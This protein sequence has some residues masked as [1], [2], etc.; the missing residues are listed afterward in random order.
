MPRK[1]NAQEKY[2]ED[3]ESE[4]TVLG[5]VLF[6][7]AEFA[8]IADL[9]QE[10]FHT[11]SNQTIFLV[12]R[13][14]ERRGDPVDNVSLANEL[15]DRKE[16]DKIGGL[17]YLLGLAD[18]VPP[19][20]NLPRYKQR[21]QKK[22]VTRQVMF[23]A[24]ATLDHCLL[25]DEPLDKILASTQDS[26]ADIET[27]Y[28][29]T[30]GNGKHTIE[31]LPSVWEY[32]IEMHWLLDG[33]IAQGSVTMLTG[34][35]GDGKSFLSL[36]LAGQVARGEPFLSRN[37]IK[38]RVLYLDRENPLFVVKERLALMNIRETKDLTYWGTWNDELPDGPGSAAIIN[39]VEKHKPLVIFDN[40]AAFDGGDEQDATA[41]RAHMTLYRRLASL[42]GTILVLHNTGKSETSKEY[43]GS[44]DIKASL[45]MGYVLERTDGSN[46]GQPLGSM[47][48]KPFKTRVLSG[49]I[50]FEYADGKFQASN[51]DTPA[52][53]AVDILADIL[54]MYPN[55]SQRQII[56]HA[57][58][59]G[60]GK[61]KIPEALMDGFNSGRF[62]CSKNGA[63][64][65]HTRK[66]A[67]KGEM[68]E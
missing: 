29:S 45:D 53:P 44:S 11:R 14:L 40:K 63:S 31:S 65:G 54:R 5:S 17:T 37:T 7:Q 51:T 46:S 67:L 10:D 34:E 61:F 56:S 15:V 35:S 38:T 26:F 24:Q 48:L 33:V 47:I 22:T 43:R 2:P 57:K 52:R 25:E 60:L 49:G 1:K 30:N 13:E 42:G 6:G 23:A 36:K 19:N 68:D 62:V 3:F 32:E 28:R 16:L 20:P 50:R 59:F 39:F 18:A 58:D 64:R 66:W 27:R 12:M 4:R 9:R 55:S 8:A 41:T 21:L